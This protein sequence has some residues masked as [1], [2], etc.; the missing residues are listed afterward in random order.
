MRS[1]VEGASVFAVTD[2]K[3]DGARGLGPTK[4]V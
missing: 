2:A 3:D 4:S 1:H